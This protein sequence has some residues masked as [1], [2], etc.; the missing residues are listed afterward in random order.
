MTEVDQEP[1]IS[2]QAMQ[3]MARTCRH[4]VGGLLQTIYAT[5]AILQDR[6]TGGFDLEHRLLADLKARAETCR[7]ELDGL[8]DL[9]SPLHF[10][11]SAVDLAPLTALSL[12]RLRARFPALQIGCD[13]PGPAEVWVDPRRLHQVLALLLVG[14]CQ[15]AVRQVEVRV[16]GGPA[17]G[18]W[19][20][21]RDGPPAG[22]DQLV[23]L[24]RPFATTH[25]A[26]LGIGLALARRVARV[27][28]GRLEAD[29]PTGGGFRVT[30]WLPAP[31][32]AGPAREQGS[33]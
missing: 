12:P 24:D 15:G 11:P 18:E 3:M 25:E 29:N 6:L 7:E 20:V 28:G 16:T 14:V 19:A 31:G 5:V 1:N 10:S 26:L 22:Q 23:W 30:L 8:A 17:G 33:L 27:H 13:A 21:R 32:A 9:V 2:A 4:E